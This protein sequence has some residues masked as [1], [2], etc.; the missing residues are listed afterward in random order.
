MAIARLQIKKGKVGGARPH[1]EY[2]ARMGK[3]AG[4]LKLGEEL[5]EVD[6]GNM[7][8]WA[9][10]NPIE[11]WQSA[12]IYERKNGRAYREFEIALPRELS[13]T[14]RI[15]L[16]RD[17]VRQELGN[18]HAYQWAIHVAKASDGGIQPHAHLMFSE[19]QV[20]G[21]SR[22]PEL[23]FRRYNAK[24][25]EAGGARKGYGERAGETLTREESAAELKALRQ[26]WQDM[27]NAH[28]E[29]AGV[30]E[31]I[32][33]RSHVERGTGLEPERKMLPSEW[34]GQGRDNV[35]EFRKARIEL[36]ESRKELASVVP[37]IPAKILNL[38]V[39]RLA[40]EKAAQEAEALRQVEIQRQ[41]AEAE[42]E[43]LAREKAAR[44]AQEQEL[45]RR[46]N[47]GDE[48]ALAELRNLSPA[49]GEQDTEFALLIISSAPVSVAQHGA[50]ILCDAG[51]SFEVHKNGHVI[52][53]RGAQEVMRDTGQEVRLAQND[54]AT[55]EAALRLAQ[56][57]FGTVLT[58]TGSLEFQEKV[59]IVAANI[60][61]DV[62]FTNDNLNKV[63]TYRQ[64]ILEQFEAQLQVTV[65]REVKAE[66]KLI[67]RELD[68]SSHE[69]ALTMVGGMERGEVLL[70]RQNGHYVGEVIMVTDTH[71]VQEIATNVV[72]AH[73]IAKIAGL[74]RNVLKAQGLEFEIRYGE[75]AGNAIPI[76]PKASQEVEQ[77]E[78]E[79]SDNELLRA[80][81]VC[82]MIVQ[83][84]NSIEEF[85][86]RTLEYNQ[87]TAIHLTKKMQSIKAQ[88]AELGDRPMWFGKDEWDK[89]KRALNETETSLAKELTTVN[90][91]IKEL[92]AVDIKETSIQEAIDYLKL[93]G[94]ASAQEIALA[95]NKD[96]MEKARAISEEI[97]KQ[98]IEKAQQD[99][100][101]KPPS[102]DRS[103]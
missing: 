30:D 4:R 3:Y 77:T 61:L 15:E 17:F 54:D 7:P 11:F 49:H 21:I 41:E 25:P 50:P 69:Y 23:Y 92:T 66:G 102:R 58:V 97:R 48:L 65:E 26:R 85:H 76:M 36:S 84:V 27:C 81:E 70:P 60:N 80:L 37:D 35:I 20:D 96:A 43:R 55:I 98:K 42:A 68:R 19:R 5:E 103:R 14:Q 78:H 91:Q 46:A 67:G 74:P 40:R 29:R 47:T 56:Q 59:A 9:K 86:T 12:D 95:C 72:I 2:I 51:L 99:R 22:D 94:K 64:Q 63:K 75:T 1:A 79:P 83:E 16:M 57:K 88:E 93:G 44:E 71:I 73:D 62:A 82:R 39:E 13:A 31:R 6:I 53:K 33:M 32:D 28:M 24:S 89:K 87:K 18:R 100:Q 8:N 34:R 10:E 52:Y 90:A 38:E 45:H 101:R